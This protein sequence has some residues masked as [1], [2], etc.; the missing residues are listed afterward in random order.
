MEAGGVWLQPKENSL[1]SLRHAIT[2]FDGI[3]FDIRR[4][5][6]NQLVLHHDREVH[7]PSESQSEQPTWVEEWTLDDLTN[8]GFLSF[9]KL[10]EDRTVQHSWSSDGKMGCV[11]I[12]R[13][14]PRARCGGGYLGRTQHNSYIAEVMK[15]IDIAL[16]EYDIPRENSVIYSFHKDMPASAK[17][18]KTTRPWAALIPYIPPY[19]NRTT[20]RTQA[21]PQYLRMPFKRLVRHHRQQGSAML[22]CAIEYFDSP[23]RLIPLGRHVGL[24]GSAFQRLNRLRNGMATYV[25]PTRLP[26]EHQMLRCGMTALTDAADPALTWLPSGHARWTQPGTKPL[27]EAEWKYLESATTENH[28]QI[29]KELQS[30]APTWKECDQQR[31]RQL[32][33]EWKTTWNWGE[34]T[35]AL[36]EKYTDATSPWST[37]R[38]IGHRGSGKTA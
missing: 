10:L 38:L 16:T 34:S 21:F 36:L 26:L 17:L 37:P 28:L 22:P 19:G 20:Q 2:Y 9:E 4:T 29:I 18:A 8:L 13:P 14:H 25:W 12:K 23:T 7:L 30:Q 24:Q 11:E 15:Q 6:D 5:A 27:T 3:E 31:R 32:V 33:S 35:D 1:P